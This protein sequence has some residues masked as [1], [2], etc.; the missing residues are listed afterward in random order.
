MKRELVNTQFF[1]LTVCCLFLS[2]T[3]CS[4]SANDI[5][6]AEADPQ[7]NTMAITFVQ[8]FFKTLNSGNSYDFQKTATETMVKGLTPEVQ[9][10]VYQSVK[11]QC[12]EFKQAAYAETYVQQT[13]PDL[14]II[15]LKADFSGCDGKW[16]LRVV[17]DGNK[18]IAGYW[19]KP[20]DDVM[21]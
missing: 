16:E 1:R 2:A 7:L 14:R 12:G 8:D 18:K 4:Q 21:M 3:A 5:Q 17:Y 11:N 6:K 10:G 9:K 20:W 13:M 19:I 15:R